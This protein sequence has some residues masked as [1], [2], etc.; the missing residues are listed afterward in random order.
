MTEVEPG[1]YAILRTEKLK[2]WGNVSA[3][4]Q[5][6]F[7]SRPTPNADP[8][9]DIHILVGSSDYEVVLAHMRNRLTGITVRKNAVM[10]IE[11][12]LTASPGY[13]RPEDPA[14][15]G[16][17]DVEKTRLFTLQSMAWAE[18]QFGAENIVSAALHV[19]ESTPH[20]QLIIQPIDP[21]GRLNASYW[22][23]GN[24][25][26][27][28]MQDDFADHVASLGLLRGLKGSLAEHSPVKK[29]YGAVG[30]PVE[31]EKPVP[32]LPENK[33]TRVPSLLA[34]LWEYP[35]MKAR[36]ESDLREREQMKAEMREIRQHNLSLRETNAQK[37][38]ALELAERKTREAVATAHKMAEEN[39]ELRK[40]A[41]RLRQIDLHD[42]LAKIYGAEKL[43]ARGG[44]TSES[45][46]L[47]DDRVITL[48]QTDKGLAWSGDGKK[49]RGAI[50]LVMF[51]D[52]L[53]FD[54]GL[55]LLATTFGAQA[56]VSESAA[57]QLTLLENNAARTI[58]HTP[59]PTPVPEPGLWSKVRGWVSEAFGIPVKLLSW[60]H[61][62][63]LLYADKGG[64]A[65]FK[66]QKSGAI[67]AYPNNKQRTMGDADGGCVVLPGDSTEV[68]LTDDPLNALAIKSMNHQARVAVANESTFSKS[69]LQEAFPDNRTYRI[70]HADS[71]KAK[72]L[73]RKLA[74][75]LQVEISAPPRNQ[76]SWLAALASH[77]DLIDE[78]WAD[79]SEG[80]VESYDAN[81]KAD[82]VRRKPG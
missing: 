10:A 18:A 79:A 55:K 71:G 80:V 59:F 9:G 14:A 37:A 5:H 29:L 30:K 69:T 28:Q 72:R 82:S 36:Y 60:V 56:T 42:V 75:E 11:V 3:S 65:V 39:A 52:G 73:A 50:D 77:V 61:E 26:L 23:D 19:D 51:L 44:G 16:H 32:R 62:L 21:R 57:L 34:D 20:L 6:N 2:T 74:G 8:E 67:I 46:Q 43:L 13:F 63:G 35:E 64:N 27:S 38:R 41:D 66:R 53:D 54:G 22:L 7:R 45:Y 76:S 24:R 40:A 12:M 58:A 1:P 68:Y 78:H 4:L 48:V 70:C 47:Q 33:W 17:F 81:H 15:S 49:G 31:E 25:K